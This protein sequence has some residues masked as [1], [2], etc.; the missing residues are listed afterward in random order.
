MSKFKDFFVNV[1]LVNLTSAD[2]TALTAS[3]A[4]NLNYSNGQRDKKEK[5]KLHRDFLKSIE[6]DE[7][8]RLTL[9]ESKSSQI[10]AQTGVIFALLSLFVPLVID[11]ID[12]FGWKLSILIFLVLAFLFYLL[13]IHNGAKNLNIGK[14]I[15][16]RSLPTNVLT[17][18]NKSEEE[19]LVEEIN[20]LLYASKQ[21]SKTNHFK[22]TNLIHAYNS[23]KVANT[24]AAV[25]GILLC[26]AVLF[27]KQKKEPITIENPVKIESINSNCGNKQ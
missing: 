14:Y 1:G 21:N 27:T 2:N 7:N 10:V 17:Y 5:L 4:Q 9:L 20:D 13:T 23:F 6:A 25:I 22:G 19:F 12:G 3:E 15:Y 16:S 8:S 24:M 18:R 11:K 26:T